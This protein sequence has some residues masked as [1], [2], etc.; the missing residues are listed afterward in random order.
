MASLNSS[1]S[2]RSEEGVDDES[3]DSCDQLFHSS[4]SMMLG[5][6]TVP[7]A[8]CAMYKVS[9]GAVSFRVLRSRLAWA[10]FTMFRPL[11]ELCSATRFINTVIQ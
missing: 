4:S 8:Q 7:R 10:V 2:A 1:S 3:H 5:R 11:Q 9:T 6:D